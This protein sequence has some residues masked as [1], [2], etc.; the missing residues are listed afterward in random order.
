MWEI[1][2][3]V[4]LVGAFFGNAKPIGKLEMS[5]HMITR[6]CKKWSTIMA[7]ASHALMVDSVTAS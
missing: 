2:I 4:R 7:P 5:S 3:G 1:A 6:T